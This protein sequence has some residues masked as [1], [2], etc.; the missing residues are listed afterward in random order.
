[1]P[2]RPTPFRTIPTTTG[3]LAVLVFVL[4]AAGT[5]AAPAALAVDDTTRPGATVLQGPSCHPGGVVVQV[6]A[7]TEPYRVVLA[8]T[9]HP[10]GE[11][12]ALLAAGQTAL[13]RTGDVDWG[14]T[15]DSRL[16]Y[17][18]EDGSGVSYADELEPFSFTRPSQQDCAAIGSAA[19]TAPA[20]APTPM[21]VPDTPGAGLDPSPA[22]VGPAVVPADGG[23]DL[24]LKA[25]AAQRPVA[26]VTRTV[27]WPAAV[28]GVAL[29]ASS[30]GLAATGVRRRAG[31]RRGGPPAGA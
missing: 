19:A 21:A 9:R 25:V 5:A 24:Q 12:S 27:D 3:R 14:E 10:E 17:T 8:T 1:V 18:A 15:I 4:L 13:L 20:T 29:V 16:E 23:V 30:A 7:G 11:D 26:P 2:T 28:A 6:T 22:A 31:I